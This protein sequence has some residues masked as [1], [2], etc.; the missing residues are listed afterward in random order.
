MYIHH[1]AHKIVRISFYIPVEKIIGAE[2]GDGAGAG[3]GD[4]A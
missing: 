1:K 4:G 2:A 3:A